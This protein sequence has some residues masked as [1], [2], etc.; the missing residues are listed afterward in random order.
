[1][2]GLGRSSET[3]Q[4]LIQMHKVIRIHSVVLLTFTL[5]ANDCFGASASMIASCLIN[6]GCNPVLERIAWFI[7]KSKQFN[8]SDIASDIAALTL[9]FN[10]NEPLNFDKPVHIYGHRHFLQIF[11][12]LGGG[13]LCSKFGLAYIN[14]TPMTHLH[15]QLNVCIRKM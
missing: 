10:V 9:M 5:S 6:W 7:K 12:L 13:V 8:Q 1:M 3:I 4:N 14:R 15:I 11:G 2:D